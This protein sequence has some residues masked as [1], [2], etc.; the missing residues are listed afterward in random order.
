MTDLFRGHWVFFDPPAISEAVGQLEY[1][2]YQFTLGRPTS[3]Q[4]SLESQILY[5]SSIA[6]CRGK[7][8]D[9]FFGVFLAAPTMSSGIKLA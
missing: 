8:D 3:F 6:S 4:T 9:S 2:K 1:G 7:I 5:G